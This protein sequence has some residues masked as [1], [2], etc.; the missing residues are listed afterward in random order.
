MNFLLSTVFTAFYK[1]GK[2]YFCFHFYQG[3]FF[4]VL[5]SFTQ[6]LFKSVLSSFHVFVNFPVFF[7]LPISSFI[8]LW[9]EMIIGMIYI[10]LNSWKF[11]LW[12]DISLKMSHVLWRGLCILLLLSRKFHICLLGPFVVLYMSAVSLLIFCLAF[13]SILENGLR[14]TF[15]NSV[16]CLLEGWSSLCPLSFMWKK[17]NY[18]FFQGPHTI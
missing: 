9:S 14:Q 3:F 8:L 16:I 4:K 13:L 7:L 5:S 12:P 17:A 6:W 2:L 15:K 10:F 18:S 1:F 11:V